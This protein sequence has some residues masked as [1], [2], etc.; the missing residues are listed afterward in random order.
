VD[1]TRFRT[2]TLAVHDTE[3]HN[4][5]RRRNALAAGLAIVWCGFTLLAQ[6]SG[7]LSAFEEP[8]IDW[9][10]ALAS[11]PLPPSNQLALVSIDNI[12]SDRPWPWSRFDYSLVLRSLIDYA[13]H[14]VIFDM[15]LNDRDTAYTSFDE[16]FSH[17][18]ER[19]NLVIFAATVMTNEGAATPP[20]AYLGELPFHGDTRQVPRFNSAIWPLATFAGDSP[21]GVNNVQ[22]EA[23]LRLRKLPLIFMLHQHMVPSM[24]L[25]AASQLLGAD[26][27]S[28]E[29]QVGR[30]IFLRRKDGHLLRTIPIDDEGRVSVRFHQGPVTSWTAD[31]DDVMVYDDQIQHGLTPDRDLRS[32]ARRQVWIGRTDSADR[33]RFNTALGKLS[34]VEVELQAERT[35]LEQDYV[36][37]L[38]PMILAALYILIGVGG[39]VGVLRLGLRHA[40]ALAIIAA[41]FWFEAGVL[42]FRLYNVIFPYPSFAM[43]IFGAYAMGVLA[44]FWDLDPEVP[45]QPQLPHEVW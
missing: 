36:R 25:Q 22:A 18:V 6:F 1:E 20:P 26:L 27:G 33:E 37:P 28:S 13:P 41:V 34:R 45:E 11:Y 10:E 30:A 3:H 38:P 29:V 8:L 14:S 9:R 43:L 4:Q 31:F 35:I 15:N 7:A 17:I 12:P 21:V 23:G 2:P 5:E 16:T 42:A 39:A 44:L 32:L 19:A 40:G 24:V